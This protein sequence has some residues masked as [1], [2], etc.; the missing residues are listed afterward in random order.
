MPRRGGRSDA[1]TSGRMS[2]VA[3]RAD[4]RDPHVVGLDRQRRPETGHLQ[5]RDAGRI[6]DQQIGGM[7][8]DRIERAAHRHAEVLIA[9]AAKILDRGEQAGRHDPQ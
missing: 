8:T 9:D 2:M 3:L 4:D 6:A 1:A 5:R 7:Q